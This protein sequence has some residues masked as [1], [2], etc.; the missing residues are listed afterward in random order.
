[1]RA[2]R[3]CSPRMACSNFAP[4]HMTAQLGIYLRPTR[5]TLRTQSLC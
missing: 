3:R 5:G 2:W 1:L 4:I